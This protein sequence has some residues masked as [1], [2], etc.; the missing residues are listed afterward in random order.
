MKVNCITN[1]T[2]MLQLKLIQSLFKC[3][4][5]GNVTFSD[6]VVEKET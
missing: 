3:T 4:T 5:G 2:S 6:A 1:R